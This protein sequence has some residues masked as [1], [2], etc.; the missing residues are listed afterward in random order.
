MVRWHSL[1]A[2]ALNFGTGCVPQFIVCYLMNTQ[3]GAGGAFCFQ[4]NF[5][6]ASQF[7]RT[8]HAAIKR[9]GDMNY[10]VATQCLSIDKVKRKGNPQ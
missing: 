10:G 4:W 8:E 3:I 5:V 7:Y 1:S 9:F 2:L 6:S